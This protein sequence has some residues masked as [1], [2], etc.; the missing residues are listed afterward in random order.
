[1]TAWFMTAGGWAGANS[2]VS[3]EQ[4][5]KLACPAT[6]A[7]CSNSKNIHSSKSNIT[8]RTVMLVNVEAFRKEKVDS[9]TAHVE[10]VVVVV[11]IMNTTKALIQKS[12]LTTKSYTQP[13]ESC[14]MHHLVGVWGSVYTFLRSKW[15]V[16]TIAC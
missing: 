1:M 6:P 15:L 13:V 14:E 3:H 8:L 11:L 2:L 12:Q 9:S 16:L 7:N 5:S 10:S 4:T